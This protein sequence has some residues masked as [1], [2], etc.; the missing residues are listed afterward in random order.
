MNAPIRFAL[1]CL[2]ASLVLLPAHAESQTH[3]GEHHHAEPHAAQAAEHQHEHAAAA[4]DGTKEHSHAPFVHLCAHSWDFELGGYAGNEAMQEWVTDG[5]RHVHYDHAPTADSVSK[6][7]WVEGARLLALGKRD[8]A[9]AWLRMSREDE[10]MA[11]LACLEYEMG[12]LQAALLVTEAVL[13]MDEEQGIPVPVSTVLSLPMLRYASGLISREELEK[14]AA[15]HAVGPGA[16]VHDYV[17]IDWIL[18]NVIRTP[19]DA[20]NIRSRLEAVADAGHPEAE[21]ALI[22]LAE[23]RIMIVGQRPGWE[24][25]L[26]AL[27]ATYPR[28]AKM[29]ERVENLRAV[30]NEC[31]P[32]LMP[33]FSR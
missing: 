7:C 20:L 12:N 18:Q 9:R 27:A 14:A 3:E 32:A 4:V 17:D 11:T 29:Q 31:L 19:E 30:L 5:L 23:M 24:Q 22:A 1:P 25:R 21:V 28:A 2:L 33:K 15:D 26:Q 16:W 6:L 8:E 10:A 13:K